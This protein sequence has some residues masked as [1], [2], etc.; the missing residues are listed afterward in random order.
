[1]KNQRY[2]VAVLG[3]TGAVGRE[4]LRV[5]D[6]MRFPAEEVI[7]LASARSVLATLKWDA[8]HCGAAASGP[9]VAF[10]PNGLAAWAM[11]QVRAAAGAAAQAASSSARVILREAPRCSAAPYWIAS[12]ATA[13][14]IHIGGAAGLH[15]KGTELLTKVRGERDAMEL[16]AAILQLYREEGFYLERVYKWMDR[17]GIASIA[18]RVVDDAGERASLFERFMEAQRFSQDDPWAERAAGHDTLE[19][20]GLG[21]PQRLAA[22]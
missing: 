1:M 18:A 21:S 3:A 4:M 6:E 16:I 8:N 17:V 14:E 15:I 22:E 2:K 11:T 10:S 20:Q 12:E 7:A 5:L 19:F 9:G 13:A